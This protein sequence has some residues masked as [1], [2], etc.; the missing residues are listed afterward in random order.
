MTDNDLLKHI[1]YLE[2]NSN[3]FKK[4]FKELDEYNTV[5][6]IY[7]FAPVIT[8][9]KINDDEKQWILESTTGSTG[10]PLSNR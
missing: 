7:S 5:D 10:Q 6:E 9:R 1:K 3:F 8:N 2:D 4:Y